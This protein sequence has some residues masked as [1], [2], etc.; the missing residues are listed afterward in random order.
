MPPLLHFFIKEVYDKC[1]LKLHNITYQKESL[2]YDA[3]H[4]EINHFKILCRS[5][6]TTPKKAGQ[7]VTFWKRNTQGITTPHHENDDLDF[8]VVNCC[9]NNHIGQFV[10]PKSILINKG[11]LSTLTKEGKRGFR[12]YPKWAKPTSKQ[13]QQT[14]KWQLNYFYEVN[15]TIDP[16]KILNLYT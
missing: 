16:K 5:G 2:D 8:Y 15:H 11:I 13:A 6:K 7:F 3:C 12:V 4:F 9:F 10:F 14:Q 1:D